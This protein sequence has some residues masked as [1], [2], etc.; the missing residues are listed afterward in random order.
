MDQLDAKNVCLFELIA[1]LACRY[2]RTAGWEA[3]M[4]KKSKK[5]KNGKSKKNG[6]KK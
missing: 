2:S 6:K 3:K 1:A 4:A 5:G